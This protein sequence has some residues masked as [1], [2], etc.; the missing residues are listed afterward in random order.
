MNELL[1]HPVG[2]EVIKEMGLDQIDEESGLGSSTQDL[3]L[4]MTIHSL[5]VLSNGSLNE[6]M[7]QNILLTVNGADK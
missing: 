1:E 4:G 6:E 3:I 5:S 2:L 7:V